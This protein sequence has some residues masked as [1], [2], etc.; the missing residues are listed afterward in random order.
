MIILIISK[1]NDIVKFLEKNPM[2]LSGF[3]CGEGYF[4]GYL[5]LDKKSLWGLQ[6]GLILILH[7]VQMINYY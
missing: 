4:T 1:L 7:K 3:T 5:S 2:W 6:P